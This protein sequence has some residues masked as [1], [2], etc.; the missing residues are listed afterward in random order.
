MAFQSRRDPGMALRHRDGFPGCQLSACF[1]PVV[2]RAWRCA[3]DNRSA[4]NRS[5]DVSIPS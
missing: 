2:I 4:D 1:N 3:A 5:A